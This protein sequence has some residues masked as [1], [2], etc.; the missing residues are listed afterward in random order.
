MDE[1]LVMERIGKG[2]RLKFSPEDDKYLMEHYPTETAAD[3]ADH[4]G[5][6]YPA[7]TRRAKELGLKKAEGWSKS[8]FYKR[9]VGNYQY[10]NYVP[11]IKSRL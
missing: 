4:F 8:L 3:I 7:V 2:K 1:S 11:E 9:Y 5:I 6:S 10:G